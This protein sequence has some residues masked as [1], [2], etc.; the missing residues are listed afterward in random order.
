MNVNDNDNENGDYRVNTDNNRNYVSLIML[1]FATNYINV[2][3]N[4]I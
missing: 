2:V 1:L 4:L 3:F